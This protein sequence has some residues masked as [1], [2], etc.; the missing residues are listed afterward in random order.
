MGSWNSFIWPL[1]VL[2]DQKFQTVPI[3]LSTFALESGK[4][5][6]GLTM[7]LAGMS[8][9]PIIIVFLFFQKYIIRSVALSGLKG[10]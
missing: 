10:E 7:G 5:Y 4:S 8:I 6:A 2:T 9:L 1:V 3:Y